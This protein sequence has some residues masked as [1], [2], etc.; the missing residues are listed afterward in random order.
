[1]S[2]SFR[3]RNAQAL[4]ETH[5]G[6]NMTPM[7]D[8]V[9]VI[10]IFFMAST[11]FLGPEWFLKSYLPTRSAAAQ[12]TAAEP[13]RLRLTLTRSANGVT[14]IAIN[15][16]TPITVNQIESALSAEATRVGPENLVVPVEVSPDVAYEDVVRVHEICDR[17][18]IRKVGLN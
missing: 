18:G 4:Y 16:A 9:M 10:L 13:T 17:L 7:V 5:V 14:Q 12:P 3:R 1:M 6:P 8:V 15:D 11:A 2:H